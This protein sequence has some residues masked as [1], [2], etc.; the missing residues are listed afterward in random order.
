METLMKATLVKNSVCGLL[1]PR[2]TINI[3]K[4]SIS[5]FQLLTKPLKC[6]LCSRE[7]KG[8]LHINNIITSKNTT[9][10]LRQG[11]QEKTVSFIRLALMLEETDRLLQLF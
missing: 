5:Y 10:Q 7:Q 3:Y 9:E 11:S 2:Y 6:R 1:E 4:W 8:K